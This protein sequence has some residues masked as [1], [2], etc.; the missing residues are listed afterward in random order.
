[1]GS[2]F[3]PK[4]L[5]EIINDGGGII[6]TGPFGSQLHASDYVDVGIPVIM[7]ANIRADRVDLTDIAR[8]EQVDAD[9]LSKHIV[10]NGDIVYSRRG[11]VTRKALITEQEEGM[12]CG[13]GC[14]LVRPGNLIDARFLY[15]H[16]STP[17]NQEWIIRHAVGATMPNLNTGILSK[18][19]LSV[20]SLPYQKAIAH[21]L[22]S[23]DDKIELNR[24]INKTLESMAQILF[25][26]WFV[27]FDP[28]IKNTLA[29]G[30]PIPDLFAERAVQQ[31]KTVASSEK[32]QQNESGLINIS[33]HS[34]Q[35]AF[36]S[37]FEFTEERGWI[38]KGWRV[39]DV[40]S[41]FNTVGGGTPSTKNSE[42]WEN[43][44][45]NWTTPKDLSG[46]QTKI[47]LETNKRITDLG[48]LKISSGLLPVDT[49]LMSSRAPVGYLALAKTPVAINQ[50]YIAIKCEKKL[51]SEY[52]LLWAD[53]VMDEIKQRAAGTT[54][55][56]ISKKSFRDISIIVPNNASV[57]L[58]SQVVKSYYDAI[59][60]NL[61]ES[62]TLEET[63][64][65][66]LPKLL[67]GEIN[68]GTLA[69]D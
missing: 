60:N 22:G 5:G 46:S 33:E 20:P 7:P 34:Q 43:G 69:D 55:A 66:L 50:G 62:L 26:S 16:L 1:M 67:S 31:G 44:D 35:S 40:G 28:V 15:Y 19:P 3:I 23:L 11:D 53:S 21:I 24:Q 4:T 45:I 30:N 64:D 61:K 41:E 52:A 37:E 36:P 65:A 58:F 42:F 39:S 2:E 51:T 54:F 27:D 48:L 25:K 17:T 29:A 12:F 6:Q 63:R 68:V 49:V 38:P 56:E 14:L 47:L 10:K 18:V 13:T 32:Y 8:I 57:D 59:A 9:R